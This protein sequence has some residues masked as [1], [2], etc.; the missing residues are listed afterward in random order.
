MT[1]TCGGFG[2]ISYFLDVLRV[3]GQ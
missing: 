2:D 3:L 1:E